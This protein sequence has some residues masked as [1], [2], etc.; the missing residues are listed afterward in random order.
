MQ[1]GV[2]LCGLWLLTLF[3]VFVGYE[4]EIIYR[5]DGGSGDPDGG[6]V[7]M[8]IAC[9]VAMPLVTLTYVVAVLTERGASKR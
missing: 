6:F 9:A 2:R 4:Q 8:L 5:I 1:H 7:Q 3:V